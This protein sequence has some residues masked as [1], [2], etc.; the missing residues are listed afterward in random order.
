MFGVSHENLIDSKHI[1][2]AIEA[3][4]N[5]YLDNSAL[6]FRTVSGH[7]TLRYG[8][9][10]PN[11]YTSPPSQD[12]FS[13]SINYTTSQTP[14]FLLSWTRPFNTIRLSEIRRISAIGFKDQGASHLVMPHRRLKESGWTSVATWSAFS[15]EE[16]RK[17]AH[18]HRL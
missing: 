2:P 9:Y 15:E 17:N 14:K 11:C 5:Y 3:E 16:G 10:G 6:G 4:D 8:R 18:V 13:F 1:F 12:I 7:T